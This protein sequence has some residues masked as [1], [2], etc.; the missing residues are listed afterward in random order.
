MTSKEWRRCN[1]PLK[2]IAALKGVASERKGRL[3]L[4]GGCRTIWHLLYDARSQRAVEVAERFADGHAN[5]EE[6]SN[7]VFLAEIPT[8]GNDFMPGE[9]RNWHPDGSI[10][11][12]VQ[13]LVEMGVLTPE[14]LE[15]DEPAVD[16]VVEDRLLAAASLAEAS[17]SRSPFDHDWWHRDIARVPWPGDWLLRCVFG[18]PFLPFVFFS[19]AWLTSEIVALAR[20]MYEQRSFE[21]MP[22]LG[23]ALKEGGCTNQEILN[24]CRSQMPHVRG[25]WVVDL[26]LGKS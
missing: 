7:A 10:P 14:Q 2:M 4:C 18:D 1:D 12:S 6:R 9:W 22:L 13:R 5:Q 8:F 21:Q 24:H 16:K 23:E 26:V 25:C 15:E 20:T 11:P 17:C 3:Y 19:P